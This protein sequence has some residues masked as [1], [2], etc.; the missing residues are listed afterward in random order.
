MNPDVATIRS[1]SPDMLVI[2]SDF[3]VMGNLELDG[4]IRL[5]GD[6]IDSQSDK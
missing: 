1:Y 5:T 4:Y 6:L 3:D 2:I